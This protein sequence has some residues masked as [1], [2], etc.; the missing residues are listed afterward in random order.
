MFAIRIER[1]FELIV[2]GNGGPFHMHQ[3]YHQAV[4]LV[5]LVRGS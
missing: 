2:Q 4:K 1:R 5:M 3:S